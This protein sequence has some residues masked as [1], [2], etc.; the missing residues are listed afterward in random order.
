[1]RC[2]SEQ[3][4]GGGLPRGGDLW[5]GAASYKERRKMGQWQNHPPARERKQPLRFP[6]SVTPPRAQPSLKDNKG[7]SL[8]LK[9]R[10]AAPS[11]P[12]APGA[13]DALPGSQADTSLWSL[14]PGLL[15]HQP[16]PEAVSPL[17]HLDTPTLG[18]HPDSGTF[19]DIGDYPRCLCPGWCLGGALPSPTP[20]SCPL[21]G[22][23]HECCWT[24]P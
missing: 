4:P 16:P 15:S 10:T 19:H 1:M 14:T 11:H 17:R 18:S 3:V 12:A 22:W 13:Q 24:V 21:S 6:Y 8:S 5:A 7:P 23:S 2:S 20:L 9:H